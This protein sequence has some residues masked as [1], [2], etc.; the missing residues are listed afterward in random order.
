MVFAC[1]QTFELN[2]D[3]FQHS[4][5]NLWVGNTG[6][7]T[8]VSTSCARGNGPF[9]TQL[10]Q[11]GG[12]KHCVGNN[13]FRIFSL[14]SWLHFIFACRLAFP[15]HLFQFLCLKHRLGSRRFHIM[16]LWERLTSNL[17][18]PIHGLET[19]GLKRWFSGSSLPSATLTFPIL[20]KRKCFSSSFGQSQC[21]TISVFGQSLC[22]K[23][24]FS[25]R[26]LVKQS[27][28]SARALAIFFSFR[29]K[30][31]IRAGFLFSVNA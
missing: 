4:V 17:P 12:W 19:L 2:Y 15:T 29:P 27:Q 1:N 11:C 30:P 24:A 14:Y 28:F 10:F 18:F 21:K 31:L 22:K 8:G 20:C 6:L 9:P 7:E 25:A 5:S 23:S 3:R 26:A 13:V 16:R